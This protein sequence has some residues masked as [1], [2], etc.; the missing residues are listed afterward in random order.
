ML[1]CVCVYEGRQLV[2]EVLYFF[3]ADVCSLRLF[4]LVHFPLQRCC[5]DT[6]CFLKACLMFKQLMVVIK[7]KTFQLNET[8]SK[9]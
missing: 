2:F 9:Y 5:T 6:S 3:F 7:R 4:L 8:F 1:K